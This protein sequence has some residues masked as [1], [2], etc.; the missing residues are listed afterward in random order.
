MHNI[1][2]SAGLLMTWAPVTDESGRV[3]MVA[4]WHAPQT[5]APSASHA[6]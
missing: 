4:Q 5:P 2:T 6:A 3:H 1:S